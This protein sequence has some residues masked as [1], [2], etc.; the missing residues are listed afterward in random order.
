MDQPAR[1]YL[2]ARCRVQVILCSRCDRGNR[3]CGMQCRHQARA[4]ARRETAQRYQRSW[5][6]RIAHAQR[7]RRWR[8]RRAARDAA[9]AAGVGAHK[10]THQGSRS[11]VASA[12]LV[13]WTHDS[14]TVDVAGTAADITA[15][16]APP[17]PDIATVASC[18]ACRRCGARQPAALRLGFVRHGLPL[19]RRHDHSP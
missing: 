5:H 19:R 3:Y 13:A 16:S 17:E 18:W 12:P 2:C 11:G 4:K 14:T 7:S 6:G 1:L 9:C 8:Q 15:P 10:V